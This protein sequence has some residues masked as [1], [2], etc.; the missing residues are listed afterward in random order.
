MPDGRV[1]YP[2]MGLARIKRDRW[3]A[4]EPIS[5]TGILQTNRL[6]WASRQLRINADDFSILSGIG[7]LPGRAQYVFRTAV[8]PSPSSDGGIIA[9]WTATPPGDRG[10]GIP[11]RS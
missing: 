8:P 11:R 6:Y 2:G 1:N 4:F 5:R 9:L 10:V 7:L 3:A